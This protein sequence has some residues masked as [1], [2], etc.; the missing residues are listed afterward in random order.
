MNAEYF[1]MVLSVSVAINGHTFQYQPNQVF[2][3]EII[4][5]LR[6]MQEITTIFVWLSKLPKNYLTRSELLDVIS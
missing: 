5:T 1:Q 6:I 2:P 3:F 4:C